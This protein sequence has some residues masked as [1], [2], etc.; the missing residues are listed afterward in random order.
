M[1]KTREPDKTYE[2]INSKTVKLPV[3][4]TSSYV[5]LGVRDQKQNDSYMTVNKSTP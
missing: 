2:D 5:S 1:S 4:G 3:T